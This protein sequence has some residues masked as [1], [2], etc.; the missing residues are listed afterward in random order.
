MQMIL[1]LVDYMFFSNL[2][3]LCGVAVLG[4]QTFHNVVNMFSQAQ[5]H[6]FYFISER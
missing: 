5:L 2:C 3:I 4:Q 1:T 6:L